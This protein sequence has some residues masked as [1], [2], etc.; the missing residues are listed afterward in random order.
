M[1]LLAINKNAAA[2]KRWML[3]Y[4]LTSLFCMIFG[5][6]YEY[7]SHEVYS[8][9]MLCAFLIPL[10]GGMVVSFLL[11]CF[12]KRI[13]PGR[14]PFNLYNSGIA[15]LTVGCIFQGVLEIY[16]TT[17]TLISV[18]WIA[19]YSFQILGIAAYL[20]GIIFPSA[21]HTDIYVR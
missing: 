13:M 7:F 10:I 15:A 18:Y 1:F 19:G 5:A 20:I 2:L 12:C 8:R 17:N 4:F 9:Y 6:V 11:N 16:G 3:G 14:I 21:N